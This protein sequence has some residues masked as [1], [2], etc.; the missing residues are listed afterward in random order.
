MTATFPGG[1]P[2]SSLLENCSLGGW[3]GSKPSCSCVF[4][5]HLILHSLY[6]AAGQVMAEPLL[7][8]KG[9]ETVAF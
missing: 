4:Q 6:C 7:G 8:K 1:T 3:A 2:V 9:M 5:N